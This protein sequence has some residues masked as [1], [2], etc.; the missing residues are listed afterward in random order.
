MEEWPIPRATDGVG[1]K[2]H[3]STEDDPL[4]V[5]FSTR[6]LSERQGGTVN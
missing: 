1:R 6:P 2:S 3:P 4:F 5:L